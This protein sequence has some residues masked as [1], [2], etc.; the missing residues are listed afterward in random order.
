MH[1]HEP[2]KKALAMFR[3]ATLTA[4][5]LLTACTAAPAPC[6]IQRPPLG[7]YTIKFTL[8]GTAPAGC[9]TVLPAIYADNWRLDKYD[10]EEVWMKADSMPYPDLGGPDSPVLGHGPLSE[11]PDS[12]NLCTVADFTPMTSTEDPL[13]MGFN[14]YVYHAKNM[15]FLDGARY[16]GSTFEADV[17]I[18]FGVC[19]GS[20]SAQGLTPSPAIV[21]GPCEDDSTCD[22]FPDPAAGRPTGSGINPDYAVACVKEDWVTTYI[23]GDPTQGICFFT[24][25]FPGLK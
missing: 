13:G 23:T 1:S 8:Q 3:L 16:Q 19:T 2:S 25:P 15:R 11:T 6:L 18:T 17:D 20:Y 12:Q 10:N 24:K 14:N 22:P 4:A 9:E 5:A 21:I 7:G